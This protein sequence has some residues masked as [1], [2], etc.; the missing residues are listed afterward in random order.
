MVVVGSIPPIYHKDV[1]L[2]KQKEEEKR[3]ENLSLKKKKN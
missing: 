2:K 3:I 1:P